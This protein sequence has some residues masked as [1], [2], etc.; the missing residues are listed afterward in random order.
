MTDQHPDL[1]GELARARRRAFS[2]GATDA[3]LDRLRDL[4]ERAARA[5]AD[6]SA[7]VDDEGV[8]DAQNDDLEAP[9]SETDESHEPPGRREW[10]RPAAVGLV[11]GILVGLLIAAAVSP[12]TWVRSPESVTEQV[13]PDNADLVPS[14]TIF[15]RTPNERDVLG[16][17]GFPGLF[18]E[19][20]ATVRWLADMDGNSLY[21]A[22]GERD[23]AVAICLLVIRQSAAGG[24][25]T[26]P[27]KFEVAGLGGTFE[28]L[29]VRWGPHGVA[30]W[31]P[32]APEAP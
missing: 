31:V 4:E 15:D 10:L 22:R 8:P 19:G 7:T 24:G 30:P 16:A 29:S 14:L 26:T 18:D 2:R 6:L 27:E 5:A 23:G 21:A 17:A 20:S 9:A 32:F 13:D 1:D 3:D 25:C 28:G 12:L 11:G